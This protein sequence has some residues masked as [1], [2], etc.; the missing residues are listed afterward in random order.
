M[1]ILNIQRSNQFLD[2]RPKA[3][4]SPKGRDSNNVRTKITTEV[5]IPPANCEIKTY[6]LKSGLPPFQQTFKETKIP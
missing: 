5:S 2:M 1:Y 4:S 3:T 6:K